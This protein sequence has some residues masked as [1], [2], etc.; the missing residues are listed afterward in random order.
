MMVDSGKSEAVFPGVSMLAYD[1]SPDDKQVVYATAGRDGKS[2][3]W[4]APIDRALPPSRLGNRAKRRLTLAPG[5]NPVSNGRG[6]RQL[7]GGD[8]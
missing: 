2:Q 5:K 4:V 8:E 7:P 1:V 3:L 6:K